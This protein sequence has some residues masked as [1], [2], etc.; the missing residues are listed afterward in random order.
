MRAALRDIDP[1]AEICHA[2]GLN[3]D[4]SAVRKEIPHS[5]RLPLSSSLRSIATSR[6]KR[7]TLLCLLAV[8]GKT[9]GTKKGKKS[10]GG[11]AAST[12]AASDLEKNYRGWQQSSVN[13]CQLDSLKQEGLLPLVEKMKTRAPGDEVIPCPKASERVCFVGF[14]NRG[15]AF[16]VHEFLRGLMYAYGVQLHDF[17]T[18]F[19]PTLSESSPRN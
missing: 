14:V 1:R 19:H 17:T 9:T 5:H 13:E 15:F 6:I 3:M 11:A 12:G 4:T 18:Q 16:H 7:L 10:A 2:L 8:M